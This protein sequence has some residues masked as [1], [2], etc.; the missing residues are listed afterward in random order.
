MRCSGYDYQFDCSIIVEKQNIWKYFEPWIF[1]KESKL[2][3]THAGLNEWVLGSQSNIEDIERFL[4]REY[5]KKYTGH[6][7]WIG[8]SRGGRSEFGGIFWNDWKSD[9]WRSVPGLVQIFGHTPISEITKIDE[10]NYAIDC[11]FKKLSV[12][13]YDEGNIKII[14]S[15]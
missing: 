2:L 12:I 10:N 6:V 3:L 14:D 11:S 9:N 4:I 1:D 5:D 7:F 8:K 13:E 15:L